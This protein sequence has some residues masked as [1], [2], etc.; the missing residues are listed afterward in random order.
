MLP[1]KTSLCSYVRSAGHGSCLYN[2]E[3]DYQQ[4]HITNIFIKDMFNYGF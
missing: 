1:N 2:T 4:C 3:D